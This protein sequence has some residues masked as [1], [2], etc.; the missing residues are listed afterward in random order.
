[1]DSLTY[2]KSC[3]PVLIVLLVSGCISTS[4]ETGNGVIIKNYDVGFS[5]VYSG[6]CV[7]FDVLIK[8][9]GSIKAEDVFVELVGLDEGW[10]DD[11]ISW[12]RGCSGTGGGPWVGGEKLPN[13]GT[14]RYTSSGSELLPPDI[15][16][17][18][19]GEERVCSWSYMAP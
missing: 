3:I 1:M 14:C 5:D 16:R 11:E 9:T 7:D 2:A 13:E 17:G 4:I 18:T 19:E 15:L 12:G 8:N 6:E 10:S